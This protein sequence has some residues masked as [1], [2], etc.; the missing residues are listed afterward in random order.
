MVWSRAS[1]KELSAH[2]IAEVIPQRDRCRSDAE[3]N[4]EVAVRD[5]RREL[6]TQ[7]DSET[8]SWGETRNTKNQTLVIR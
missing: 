1:R 2:L 7:T 5:E 6:F 8:S 3:R 4:A